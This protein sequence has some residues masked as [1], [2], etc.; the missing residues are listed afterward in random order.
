MSIILGLG[1]QLSGSAQSEP[2]PVDYEAVNSGKFRPHG[3]A[4][5]RSMKDGEHYT[6]LTDD[7]MSIVRYRFSDGVAVDTLLNITSIAPSARI[8]DYTLSKDEKLILLP[9][10]REAIYRHSF[11]AEH[12]IYDRVDRNYYPLSKNG[13][14]QAATIAPDSRSA[15]FVR[16]NNLYV[17]DLVTGAER[18]VT[19]DGERGSVLN[20]ITDWVYE[21]EY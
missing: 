10:A 2:R 13:K 16:N 1:T 17:V 18:A 21:E 19:S 11:R 8:T 6:A 9:F 20:G 7:R 4:G 3:V 5:L 15:A 14:Q 12:W